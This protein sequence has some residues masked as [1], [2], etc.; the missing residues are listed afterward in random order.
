VDEREREQIGLIVTHDVALVS[1]VIEKQ[2]G[3]IFSS[4]AA[5]GR[6]QSGAT[7]KV[8]VATMQDT[9]ETFL[10]DLASKI[11]L[12]SGGR[13]RSKSCEPPFSIV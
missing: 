8:S 4:H 9:A 3:A 11:K 10:S 12:V 1:R 5:N 6:L 7:I 13:K 2:L